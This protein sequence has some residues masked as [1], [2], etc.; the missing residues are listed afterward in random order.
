MRGNMKTEAIEY[1]CRIK[2][3]KMYL[4]LEYWLVGS[5]SISY[6]PQECL[7]EF[8]DMV[9]WEFLGCRENTFRCKIPVGS[10]AMDITYDRYHCHRDRL[11]AGTA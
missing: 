3:S 4:S 2:E 6:S 7:E 8:C 11:E 1:D 10:L 9:G 5:Y